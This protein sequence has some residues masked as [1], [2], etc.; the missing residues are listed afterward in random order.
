M[1]CARGIHPIRTSSQPTA[2]YGDSIQF[3]SYRDP[4]IFWSSFIGYSSPSPTRTTNQSNR[5]PVS[6]TSWRQV[7]HIDAIIEY[8][9]GLQYLGYQFSI[10]FTGYDVLYTGQHNKYPLLRFHDA[11]TV[12]FGSW[13]ADT[14]ASDLSTSGETT[15]M[16]GTSSH[17]TPSP[18]SGTSR[19]GSP[20]SSLPQQAENSG[21]PVN[22][23]GAPDVPVD[24]QATDMPPDNT[25][26][27]AQQVQ[28]LRA[29]LRNPQTQDSSAI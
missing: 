14:S 9:F 22:N 8:R 28:S 1:A 24:D 5:F 23:D 4:T 27:L 15:V 10:G 21:E 17:P 11:S 6:K 16:P 29:T 25:A 18:G 20:S 13:T 7:F 26:L 19:S 2:A 12:T 3:F